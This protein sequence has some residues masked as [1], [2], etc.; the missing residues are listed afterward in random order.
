MGSEKRRHDRFYISLPVELVVGKTTT[1][2]ETVDVSFGGLF[3]RT[4]E[5]PPAR[6]L[7]KLN[8]RIP[9]K[10]KPLTVMAMAVFVE[11]V[12]PSHPKAGVGLKLFGMDPQLQDTWEQFVR[13]V[14]TLPRTQVVPEKHAEQLP[15]EETSSPW[16]SLIPELRIRVRSI[17][18]LKKIA[19]RELARGRMYVRTPLFFPPET[20]VDLQLVHPSSNQTYSIIASID[21]KITKPDFEGLRVNLPALTRA[22]KQKLVFFIR[23]GRSVSVDIEGDSL[24]DPDLVERE[25]AG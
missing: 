14:Q 5:P 8:L 24:A 17:N 1:T 19:Q 13:H 7:V 22:Q 15:V 9:P 3:L 25:K 23:H 16:S 12:K 6:Q 20:K 21:G 18:D 4:T 11:E 10:D 2:A